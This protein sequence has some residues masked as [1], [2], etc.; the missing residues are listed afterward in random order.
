MGHCKG[1]NRKGRRYLQDGVYGSTAMSYACPWYGYEPGKQIMAF[2]AEWLRES[3]GIQRC[4]DG[5]SRQ[6]GNLEWHIPPNPACLGTDPTSYCKVYSLLSRDGAAQKA[7]NWSPGLSNCRNLIPCECSSLVTVNNSTVKMRIYCVV[8]SRG[9]SLIQ[10]FRWYDFLYRGDYKLRI[11][12][13]IK[14]LVKLQDVKPAQKL[15]NLCT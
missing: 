12:E 6:H 13:L 8:C 9:T 10:I 2:R 15:N 3:S 4:S 14:E 11:L 7:E 1:V 5:I